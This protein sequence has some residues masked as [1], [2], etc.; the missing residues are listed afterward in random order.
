MIILLSLFFQFYSEVVEAQSW[1]DDKRPLLAST[2]YGKDE[3]SVVALLKKL[4]ALDLDLEAFETNMQK[5]SGLSSGLIERGHFDSEDIQQ[6]Q[7]R[8]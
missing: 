3:D 5:L 6:R 2:D 4:D 8:D 7:V 1:M